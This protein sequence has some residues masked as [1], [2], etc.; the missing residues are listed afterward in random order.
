MPEAADKPLISQVGDL[1]SPVQGRGCR[2]C[3]GT[4]AG[5]S[6][7][8]RR[9]RPGGLDIGGGGQ[10]QPRAQ[11]QSAAEQQEDVPLQEIALPEAVLRVLCCR[12]ESAHL[13]SNC[14]PAEASAA[15]R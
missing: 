2:Y 11:R 9:A 3:S 12:Y 1:R 14:V 5:A 4:P 7:S 8:Q 13:L 10:Q 15:L 6:S